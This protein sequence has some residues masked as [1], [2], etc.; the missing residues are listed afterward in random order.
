M[1]PKTEK[2]KNT[3]QSNTGLKWEYKIPD[4]VPGLCYIEPKLKSD[5]KQHDSSLEEI[6]P[7]TITT[8]PLELFDIDYMGIALNSIENREKTVLKS[9]FS[10]KEKDFDYFKYFEESF[11]DVDDIDH[12]N[13]NN[14]GVKEVYDVFPYTGTS[15]LQIVQV[16]DA[17]GLEKD[18]VFKM[19][20]CPNNN[21]YKIATVGDDKYRCVKF[22]SS[23][24]LIFEIEGD[25]IYYHF[26]DGTYRFTKE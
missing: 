21:L 13:D 20:D 25:K 4:P 19:E 7:P 8:N 17:V 18:K 15:K 1:K 10:S 6:I 11:D 14:V 24:H 2:D 3:E 26:I 5:F 23:D 9:K 12:P 16:D 22:K